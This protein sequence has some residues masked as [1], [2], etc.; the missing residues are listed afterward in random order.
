MWRA[1]IKDRPKGTEATLGR[2]GRGV[3]IIEAE[4]DSDTDQHDGTGGYERIWT[5][6]WTI[7]MARLTSA[8]LLLCVQYCILHLVQLANLQNSPAK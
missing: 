5:V 7:M 3:M 4:N 6:E 8:E 1:G 2:S